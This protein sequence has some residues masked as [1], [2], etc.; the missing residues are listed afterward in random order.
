MTRSKRSAASPMPIQPSTRSE[1]LSRPDRYAAV[2]S[3]S[4][5]GCSGTTPS[6]PGKP[7]RSQAGGNAVSPGGDRGLSHSP[8]AHQNFVGS[9]PWLCSGAHQ[10]GCDLEGVKGA[11]PQTFTPESHV[12]QVT[13]HLH[14]F[15]HA[16]HW[17]CHEC[18][19]SVDRAGTSTSAGRSNREVLSPWWRTAQALSNETQFYSARL[20]MA[21]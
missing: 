13:R 20:S 16:G 1:L 19:S 7:C 10:K 2:V 6:K 18:Q 9:A 12:D 15:P 3:Q 21:A 8:V 5:D 14:H 4:S 17:C 11:A